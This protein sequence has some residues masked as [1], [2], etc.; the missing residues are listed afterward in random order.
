MLTSIKQKISRNKLISSVRNILNFKPTLS[1][2]PDNKKASV[3]DLFYWECRKNFDTKFILTNVASHVIP[4]II[5]NDNVNFIVFNNIGKIIL[6]KNYKLKPY[7]TIEIIFSD[8]NLNGYGSFLIF[9]NFNN[10]G[11]LLDQG[12]HI[13]E[14]GYVGYKYENSI[15]NFVHGNYDAC[16]LLSNL[17]IESIITKSFFNQ[18]YMPQV[19]FNDTDNF[20]IIIINPS[21]SITKVCVNYYD[22]S[23]RII[24]SKSKY[25]RSF[26]TEIFSMKNKIIDF[27]EIKSKFLMCRPIIYKKYKTYFDI[28][29]G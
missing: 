21:K 8:L 18:T 24:D 10:L 20:K 9:H 14:R 5:Q 22:F 26:N 3:S 12:C 29:H 28:F 4:N 23:K 19:T 2:L 11:K 1:Y 7:E 27:I 15:W 6:E 16:Y 13:A 17:K 25:I